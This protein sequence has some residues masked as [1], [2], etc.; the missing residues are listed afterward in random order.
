MLQSWSLF[1]MLTSLPRLQRLNMERTGSLT[2]DWRLGKS[3]SPH[4]INARNFWLQIPINHPIE[5][6]QAPHNVTFSQLVWILFHAPSLKQ[7]TVRDIKMDDAIFELLANKPQDLPLGLGLRKLY[8][9]GLSSF[10]NVSLSRLIEPLFA[11]IRHLYL[12][13]HGRHNHAP[14]ASR[15]VIDFLQKCPHLKRVTIWNELTRYGEDLVYH[16]HHPEISLPPDF[17]P[18]P[19]M[20]RLEI[21]NLTWAGAELKYAFVRESSTW[22]FARIIQMQLV[23][24]YCVRYVNVIFREDSHRYTIYSNLMDFGHECKIPRWAMNFVSM[25]R[26][27]WTAFLESGT[28]CVTCSTVLQPPLSLV[29]KTSH[30]RNVCHFWTPSHGSFHIGSR[31]VWVAEHLYRNSRLGPC[32]HQDIWFVREKCPSQWLNPAHH[33]HR[34]PGCLLP[35]PSLARIE[36]ARRREQWAIV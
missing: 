17:V 16:A 32:S 27:T 5:S 31:N 11:K 21:W 25:H 30:V 10:K 4:S 20:E 28:L 8:I 9:K 23:D 36:A 33:K 2:L 13:F 24:Q 26:F 19:R 1:S 15:T 34:E 3:V 35:S 7:L 22:C 29:R 12:T 14:A 18:P 6:L